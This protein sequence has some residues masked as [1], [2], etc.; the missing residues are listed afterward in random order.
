MAQMAQ[1]KVENPWKVQESR[2]KYAI[3]VTLQHS[4]EDV[5]SLANASRRL[6]TWDA[7]TGSRFRHAI[8]VTLQ[9]SRESS[10]AHAMERLTTW[11]AMAG[12]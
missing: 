10:I 9:H 5:S 1:I 11:D 4:R 6:T 3:P 8:C 7:M 12:S 2:F